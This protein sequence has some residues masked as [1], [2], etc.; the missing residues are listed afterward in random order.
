MM[1]MMGS[2]NTKPGRKGM[3]LIYHVSYL[4]FVGLESIVWVFSYVLGIG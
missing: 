4:G 3:T 2:I 1:M